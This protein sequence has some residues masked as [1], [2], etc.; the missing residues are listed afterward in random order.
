MAIKANKSAEYDKRFGN[1]KESKTT[2]GGCTTTGMG[3][4]GSSLRPKKVKK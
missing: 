1:T 4:L 2:N 3:K